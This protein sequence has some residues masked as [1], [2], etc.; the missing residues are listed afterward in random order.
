VRSTERQHL[1]KVDGVG[2]AGRPPDIRDDGAMLLK[3]RNHFR[4]AAENRGVNC[5]DFVCARIEHSSRD[6]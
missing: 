5:E 2:K 3:Y 1:R 6:R 4:A